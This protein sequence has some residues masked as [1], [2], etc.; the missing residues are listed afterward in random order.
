MG[1][2]GWPHF[3]PSK[4][5]AKSVSRMATGGVTLKNKKKGKENNTGASPHV[6]GH[7]VKGTFRSWDRRAEKE[8]ERNE[9]VRHDI[10][11]QARTLGTCG[12]RETNWFIGL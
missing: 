12:K 9:I 5:S 4:E 6:R 3:G 10:A 2:G 1:G 11:I 8:R 7:H